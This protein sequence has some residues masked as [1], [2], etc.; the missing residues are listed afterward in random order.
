MNDQDVF[1]LEA[2]DVSQVAWEDIISN[3]YEA[4]TVYDSCGSSSYDCDCSD[5]M[6]CDY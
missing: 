3:V 2:E 4:P 6:R 5:T 1:D